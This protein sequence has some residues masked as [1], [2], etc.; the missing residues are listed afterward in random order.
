MTS[1]PITDTSPLT[2]LLYTTPLGEFCRHPE[3]AGALAQDRLAATLAPWLQAPDL[4]VCEHRL[5]RDWQVERP[6][7]AAFAQESAVA[8]ETEWAGMAAEVLQLRL[9]IHL[10]AHRRI[11]A[12]AV[13]REVFLPCAS[14]FGEPHVTC[15]LPQGLAL[16]IGTVRM[17]NYW[18]K[19]EM[20]ARSRVWWANRE[21]VQAVE[22]RLFPLLPPPG[23]EAVEQFGTAAALWLRLKSLREF[24][25]RSSLPLFPYS[26]IYPDGYCPRAYKIRIP[27]ETM[28]S[29]GGSYLT[30]AAAGLSPYIA[31]PFL[32]YCETRKEL[33]GDWTEDLLG[34]AIGKWGHLA[35]RSAELGL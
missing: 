17:A 10:T 34:L 35:R 4:F 2:R 14:F 29:L 1:A 18:P 21:L 22:R 32:A 16:K 11:D 12:A 27:A 33:L 6:E 26:T 23:T 8:I 25:A 3:I 15:E 24:E 9:L 28:R 13:G 30:L 31:D 5:F 19:P 7:A 20:E